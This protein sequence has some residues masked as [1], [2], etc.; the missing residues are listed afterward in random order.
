MRGQNGGGGG[1]RGREAV[2]GN[3]MRVVM[4]MKLRLVDVI[5]KMVRM[6]GHVSV[7]IVYIVVIVHVMG[8]ENARRAAYGRG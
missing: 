1:G 8:R 5:I 7:I 2:T 3:R 4:M 6:T